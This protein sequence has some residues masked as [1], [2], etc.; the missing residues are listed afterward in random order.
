MARVPDSL[1]L[2]SLITLTSNVLT[3][4]ELTIYCLHACAGTEGDTVR[5]LTALKIHGHQPQVALNAGPTP[6]L[7]IL[8][9]SLSKWTEPTHLLSSLPSS[10]LPIQGHRSSSFPWKSVPRLFLTPALSIIPAIISLTH[11]FPLLY[12]LFSPCPPPPPAPSHKLLNTLMSFPVQKS[13]HPPNLLQPSL[14][15]F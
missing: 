14:S 2:L 7:A 5:K 15:L 11:P 10:F 6:C 9:S 12:L 3:L 4:A 8:Y 13:L 1:A